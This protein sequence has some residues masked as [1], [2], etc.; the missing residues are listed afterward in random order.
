M[1]SHVSLQLMDNI[2][3]QYNIG[4]VFLLLFGLTLL[5]VL[6]LRSRKVLSLHAGVF[7]LLFV[8]TPVGSLGIAEGS[9]LSEPLAYKF[10]GLVLV[11]ASPILYTTAR[12]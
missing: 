4:D 11:L 3:L 8:L 9:L 5:G 10:L 6:V 2:L 12:R 1:V 7:G